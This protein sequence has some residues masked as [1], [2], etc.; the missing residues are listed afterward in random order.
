MPPNPKPE[1]AARLVEDVHARGV[2]STSNG[3]FRSEGDNVSAVMFALGGS[4][5]CAIACSTFVS[6]AMP[7]AVSRCP[8]L[9]FTEPMTARDDAPSH[10]VDRLLSSTPSPRGVPVP[11]HSTNCTSAGDQPACAYAARI[12]R[13]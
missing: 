1:T 3:V 4:S 12:A 7:A 13:S 9:L 6:P 2:S 10:I 11:W 5:P 8:T